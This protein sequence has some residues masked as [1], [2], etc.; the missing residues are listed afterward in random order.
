MRGVSRKKSEERREGRADATPRRA[1]LS[2]RTVGHSWPAEAHVDA[3][4]THHTSTN[5]LDKQQQQQQQ[6]QEQQQRQQQQQQQQQRG[7]STHLVFTTSQSPVVSWHP[8][9]R[10]DHELER[11]PEEKAMLNRRR[12]ATRVQPPLSQSTT[13]PWQQAAAAAAAV[14]AAAHLAR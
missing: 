13:Q 8:N 3:A 12:Y 9:T 6:Q 11:E 2:A 1:V 4:L 5:A 10:N 14:V 7:W